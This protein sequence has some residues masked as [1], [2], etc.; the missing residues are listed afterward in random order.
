MCSGKHAA[1]SDIYNWVTQKAKPKRIQDPLT[2][3]CGRQRFE[4]HENLE[5]PMEVKTVQA[6]VK[7]LFFKLTHGKCHVYCQIF[8]QVEK[9]IEYEIRR[10]RTTDNVTTSAMTATIYYPLH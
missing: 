10:D 9:E 5:F 1:K 4:L 7:M 8:S 2:I 3:V 6:F